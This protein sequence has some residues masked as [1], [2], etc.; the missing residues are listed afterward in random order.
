MLVVPETSPP[1]KIA[2]EGLIAFE[3]T[4]DWSSPTIKTASGRAASSCRRSV[5]RFSRIRAT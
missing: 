5:P 2:I 1:R 3:N 4:S